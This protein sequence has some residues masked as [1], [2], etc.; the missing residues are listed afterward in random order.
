M[1]QQLHSV[2]SPH[3]LA[4]QSHLGDLATIIKRPM[5]VRYAIVV[6]R[7]ML[8]HIGDMPTLSMYDDHGGFYPSVLFCSVFTPSTTSMTFVYIVPT[9][10]SVYPCQK[11]FHEVMKFFMKF[12]NLIS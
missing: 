2:W 8:T 7:R 12:H 5:K 3:S 10:C 4:L 6:G 1:F 9:T 11:S